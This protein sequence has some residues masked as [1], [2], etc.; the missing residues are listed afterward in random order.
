MDVKFPGPV[1]TFPSHFPL[2]L[3]VFLFFLEDISKF[4]EPPTNF[5]SA[6]RACSWA[7]DVLSSHHGH[8]HGAFSL[9]LCA[10]PS[11]L[12]AAGCLPQPPRSRLSSRF[13]EIWGA[14]KL[15]SSTHRKADLPIWGLLPSYKTIPKHHHLGDF[16]PGVVSFCQGESS[17][18]SRPRLCLGT[19]WRLIQDPVPRPTLKLLVFCSWR[20]SWRP[21]RL[22]SGRQ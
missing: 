2:H 22:H 5:L 11:F 4:T 13:L 3:L 8:T 1:L 15:T 6:P 10:V 7:S 20:E 16:S 14:R 9:S 18:L 21:S 17:H 19:F 12:P